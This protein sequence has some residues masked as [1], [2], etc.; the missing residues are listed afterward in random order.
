MQTHVLKTGKV[1][2]QYKFVGGYVT[3]DFENVSNIN[4]GYLDKAAGQYEPLVGLYH[5]EQKAV[6]EILAKKRPQF[7]NEK[8]TITCNPRGMIS[9]GFIRHIANSGYECSR[10]AIKNITTVSG[11]HS[12][13]RYLANLAQCD[14]LNRLN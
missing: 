8:G 1:S 7:V 2:H 12:N 3:Y 9:E 5:M 11:G 10:E 4:R 14:Y 13:L 6:P